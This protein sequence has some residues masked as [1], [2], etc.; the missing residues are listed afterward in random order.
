M[1]G[2]RYCKLFVSTKLFQML[3]FEMMVFLVLY[4]EL[5]ASGELASTLPAST[6]LNER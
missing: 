4:Q 5:A 1:H 3:H 2:T 6:N